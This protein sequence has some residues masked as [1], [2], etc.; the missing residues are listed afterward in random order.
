MEKKMDEKDGIDVEKVVENED[1][2]QEKEEEREKRRG[3]E[4]EILMWKV[5]GEKEEKGDKIEE[6]REK[7]KKEIDN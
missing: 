4:G 2:C 1:V 3:V 6:V 7:E 5:G